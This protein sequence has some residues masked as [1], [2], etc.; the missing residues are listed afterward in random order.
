MVA[1]RGDF[2]KRVSLTI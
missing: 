1:N 2:L